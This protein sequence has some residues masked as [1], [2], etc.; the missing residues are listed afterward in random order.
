MS[1]RC[2]ACAFLVNLIQKRAGKGPNTEEF[3][4]ILSWI[5]KGCEYLDVEAPEVCLGVRKIFGDEIVKVF[6][7]VSNS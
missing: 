7:K 6:T 1:T 5:E 4:S 2:S 3:K